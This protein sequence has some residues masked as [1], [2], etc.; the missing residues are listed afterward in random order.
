ME[1]KFN[2]SV[3]IDC[4]K[5]KEEKEMKEKE[6]D[7]NKNK[8]EDSTAFK[9]LCNEIRIYL[10]QLMENITS[11]SFNLL[12]ERKLTDSETKDF[13]SKNILMNVNILFKKI[14]QNVQLK[15]IVKDKEIL[16]F[17]DE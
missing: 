16:N 5:L 10:V 14:M 2:F 8:F 13:A 4:S 11:V 1:H 12:N 3:I 9:P 15:N 6:K 7:E 17:I